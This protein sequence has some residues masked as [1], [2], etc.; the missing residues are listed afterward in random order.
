[1]GVLDGMDA[2]WRER[3]WEAVSVAVIGAS[4]AWVLRDL[5]VFGHRDT[6]F[7]ALMLDHLQRAALGET[8]WRDAPLAWPMPD[9]I[10]QGDWILGEALL[11]LPLR[12]AD[13]LLL[14]NVAAAVGLFA[15]AWAVHRVAAALLGPGPHTW[16]A[17]VAGALNPWALEHLQHVNL[18]QHHLGVLGALLVGAGLSRDRAPIAAAGGALVALQFHFGAY[19]GIYGALLAVV[20]AAAAAIGRQ[21]TRRSWAAAL[22][23]LVAAGLTVFPVALVYL[24]TA[25]FYG[26][27]HDVAELTAESWRPATSILPLFGSTLHAPLGPVYAPDPANPGY[28]VLALAAVGLWAVRKAEPRW[29]WGAVVGVIALSLWLALGPGVP[30]PYTLV[31]LAPGGTGVRAPVRWVGVAM[32][33]GGVLAAAGAKAIGEALGPRGGAVA[34]VLLC[35]A[36]LAEK[37]GQR[38]AMDVR[39]EEDAVYAAVDELPPGPI[40][41]EGVLAMR[42]TCDHDNP[43]GLR[44]AVRH[45]RPTL[46]GRYAPRLE[47]LQAVNDVAITWPSPDA[48]TLVRATGVVGIVDHPPLA[49][50]PRGASC[51][52]VDGHNV[53]R[54]DQPG[55][56]LP[57]ADALVPGKAGPVVGVRYPEGIGEDRV[58]VKCDGRSFQVPVPP[59]RALS[60]VRFGARSQTVDVVFGT[61]CEQ[62][63]EVVPPGQPL[64]RR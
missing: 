43:A 49:E 57:E 29:A 9:A 14:S 59:W 28:A 41:D 48:A 33:A 47:A 5:R 61:P 35:L 31:V 22:G 4:V 32:L 50:V 27:W 2:R 60:K 13:P 64:S 36:V 56:P 30:G 15:T 21:G 17:A 16:V 46:G 18:V 63:P 11:T 42:V 26:A 55:G 44:A 25:R 12:G 19:V 53:C 52:E 24:R 45:R 37:P 39:P 54:I 3:S 10:T 20:T 6:A 7:M 34:G 38:G 58:A 23:G 8:S 51:K 1:V 40:Y 62:A